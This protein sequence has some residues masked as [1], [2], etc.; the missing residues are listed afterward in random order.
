M[1]RE[2]EHAR[3][4]QNLLHD[5]VTPQSKEELGEKGGRPRCRRCGGCQGSSSWGQLVNTS[6]Q[7]GLPPD[8]PIDPSAPQRHGEYNRS[9]SY[10]PRMWRQVQ[11]AA[12]RTASTAL[13]P[14]ICFTGSQARAANPNAPSIPA[15]QGCMRKERWTSELTH[16]A[17][18]GG[19][20]FPA[21]ESLEKLDVSVNT[22]GES[23]LHTACL[24][25][26][27]ATVH[28]LLESR[29]G[30]ID[31]SDHQGRRPV[32]M[33]LTSRSSPN[34]SKCLR[35]LLEHGADV[36]ATTDSGTTPLH[37]AASE[38]FLDCTEI[39]VRAGA[40]V[41][42]QDNEGHTPLDLARIWCRRKV[43]RFLKN[44]TWQ[45]DKTKEMQE[46]MLGQA[47]YRDLVDMKL[48]DPTL[49][50]VRMEQWAS[51][52]GLPLLKDFS[53]RVSVSRYHTRCL[54]S[55]ENTSDLKHPKHQVAG[56]Q[57]DKSTPVKQPPAL[58]P[59]TIFMPEKPSIVL[60][61]RDSVRVWRD[62][63]SRR[64]QYNT[65]WD[66]RPFLAP[67]LPL[68][69]LERVLFPG[70]FPSRIPSPRYFEPR[71]IVEVQRRGYPQGRRTSPWTE[72]AMHL[73]EVLEPG[74]Y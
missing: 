63:S 15:H 72:V 39:L 44:C 5:V 36:N 57:E 49:T 26:Q 65:K 24:Y 37:L 42:A 2:P 62:S 71:D 30:W 43:A 28:L 1:Q 73:A 20:M 7:R 35:Y 6:D 16:R 29:P 19:Q 22:Q 66:T 48:N 74:H 18:P 14:L 32:H 53:P 52:K 11:G 64:P 61:L 10:G 68:D 55:D 46:R 54:Q 25:G 13:A 47:L 45:E 67:D 21:V 31:S 12:E 38:G 40:D 34:T 58:K 69:V 41:S 56:P 4:D 23:A 9:N 17:P 60:D 50:D 8:E 3:G 51:K 59:W 70:E 33:V 27:L